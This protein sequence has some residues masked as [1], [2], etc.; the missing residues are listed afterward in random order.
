MRL[1][2]I[3]ILLGTGVLPAMAGKYNKVLS[4]GDAAPKWSGLEGTD[5]QKHDFDEF[6]DKDVLIVVFTCNSCPIAADYED[7]I[8]AFVKAQM[9]RGTSVGLVAINCNTN[10]EDRLEKMK[11][12]AAK[13]QFPYPYLYDP[14]QATAKAYGARFTPEFFVLNKD[15]KVVYMGAMDDK[16]PPGT[17]TVSYLEQAVKAAL[18]G[19]AGPEE[20]IARGCLIRI[21]PRRSDDDN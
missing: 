19:Q 4:V 15:R 1:T 13:K 14:S 8:I 18:T 16:S 5:G 9:S 20:T 7:R 11:E 6:K 3:L 17:P 2:L 10:A 12:R 21:N